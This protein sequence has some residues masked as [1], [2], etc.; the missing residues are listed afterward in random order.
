MAVENRYAVIRNGV[1]ILIT[2]NKKEADE[3]DK[4][5]DIA[6][7]IQSLLQAS[8][9]E[10]EPKLAEDMSVFLAQSKQMLLQV[11]QHKKP[12]SNAALHSED[13]VSEIE[14]TDSTKASV[15]VVDT[16]ELESAS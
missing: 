2:T 15:R 14:R 9:L 16:V 6:D 3:Y 12:K 8:E 7:G 13:T 5:L 4:M 1:D 10:I 11:L